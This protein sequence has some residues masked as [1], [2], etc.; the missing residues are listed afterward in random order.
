MGELKN[1]VLVSIIVATYR[2]DKKLYSALES[3]FKQTYE[4]I[5]IVLIDDN[6]DEF[7]NERVKE[8]VDKFKNYRIIYIQNKKNLGVSE[9]R[10][11]GINEANGEYITFLDDDDVYLPNKIKNQL[12][13]MLEDNADYSITD[14]YLYDENDN[15]IDYRK[16]KYLNNFKE[17]ELLKY[18]FMYHMTGNDSLMFK[19][20]YLLKI[21]NF[22][23]V[24]YGEEFLLVEKA[25]LQ[26]GKLSYYR[27]CDIKAYVHTGET[28]LSSGKSKINGENQIYQYK[29]KHFNELDK[30]TV[31]YIKMRHWAVLAYAYLR[32]KNYKK[33]LINLMFSFLA[34]PIELIKLIVNRKTK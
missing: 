3:L 4:N 16:R 17:E 24:R 6:A 29:K 34:S 19:K 12:S 22:D 31:N 20:E 18:H 5:E 13:K 10:N 30:R 26:K 27:G 11:T 25:I 33:C 21:N 2:Q 8:I 7:W 32:M 28:G 9:T 14:L 23:L 15:I 1:K